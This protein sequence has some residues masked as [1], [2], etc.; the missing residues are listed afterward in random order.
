[1]DRILDTLALAV[2]SALW[3]TA[4]VAV[5]LLLLWLVDRTDGPDTC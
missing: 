1:M 4:I 3:A 2:Q 5:A